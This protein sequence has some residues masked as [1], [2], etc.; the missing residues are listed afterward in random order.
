MKKNIHIFIIN[1][2][3]I[4]SGYTVL[5]ANNQIYLNDLKYFISTVSNYNTYNNISSGTKLVA[6]NSK[7]QNTNYFSK[8]DSVQNNRIK[9]IWES[10]DGILNIAVT[11]SDTQSTIKI[12]VY[13]MLG[14]ELKKIFTGLPTIKNDDGDYVFSSETALNVPKGVYIIVVQGSQFRIAEKYIFTK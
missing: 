11:L 7:K 10:S 9:K 4:F 13:N 14:K 2:I 6:N 5:I 12:A 1:I 3:F 8:S